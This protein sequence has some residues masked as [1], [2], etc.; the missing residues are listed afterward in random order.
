MKIKLDKDYEVK[1]T[2]AT[3]RE[4]ERVFDKTI[5]DVVENVLEMTVEEQMKLLFTG[6][7]LA[8]PEM[9]EEE[10]LALCEEYLHFSELLKCIEIFIYALQY[11]NLSLDEAKE[12]VKQ[13]QEK[14]FEMATKESKSAKL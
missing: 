14:Y 7:K 9:K 6:V 11:P 8:N 2:L 13:R 12:K 4:I 10:F 1:V 3:A 5:S